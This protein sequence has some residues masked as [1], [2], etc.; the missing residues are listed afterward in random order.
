M[1]ITLL[2]FLAIL[3]LLV[4]IHELGHFLAARRNGVLVEEFAFG[5]RPRIWG[6]KIGETVY[7]INAIPL[8]GYVKLYGEKPE[9]SGERSFRAKSVWQRFQVLVA[10]SLMNLLLGWLLLTILFAVGFQPVFPGTE[11]NPFIPKQVGITLQ[12]VSP[13]SPAAAAGLADGDVVISFAGQEITGTRDFLDKV[14]ANLGQEVK[15]IY[16]DADNGNAQTSV[17]LTPRPNPP[18]GQ[19]ALGVA[20]APP[21]AVKS[22][23]TA[24]SAAGLYET[25]RIIGASAAGFG[26]FVKNLFFHQQVSEDVTGLIGVGALTGVARRLGVDYLAQLVIMISIGLGVLNLMPI[27]P[28]DG[29]HIAALGYEKVAGRPLS[30]RQ[31]GWLATAGLAFVLLVFVVVTFKDVIRFNLLDRFF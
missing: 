14:K 29:G 21:A 25:G 22:S 23:L 18:V 5:F 9:E 1:F 16:L 31:L 17:L 7:A 28:L 11:N 10:G 8:G 15:L 27:L 24:A 20:I 2:V 12:K 6:K 13:D 4:F 3:G 19:G 30:E 26:Q